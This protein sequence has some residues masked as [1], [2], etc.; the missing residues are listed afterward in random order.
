MVLGVT[1]AVMSRVSSLVTI[2]LPPMGTL[3]VNVEDRG[4][5]PVA[6]GLVR[7]GERVPLGWLPVGKPTLVPV[8]K[9]DLRIEDGAP[10]PKIFWQRSVAVTVGDPRVLRVRPPK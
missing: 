5:E 4:S 2:T 3:Q 1:V 9:W 7:P 8:G 10:V 6:V